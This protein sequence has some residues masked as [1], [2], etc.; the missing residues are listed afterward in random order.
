[1]RFASQHFAILG[2][3]R[4]GLGAA[5]L[6][7]LHGAE[8]TIFDEGDK[9]KPVED[10]RCVLGQAA[11]DLVVKPGEFQQV[12]ISPGLDEH[13]PLPKKFTDA[14]VPLVGETEFAFHLTDMP[15]VAITGTNGKSTCTELIATLFNGCD[16]KSLPCGN[17]GVS[18]SEVVASGVRY[19]V[20]ALEISSFQL[21]TIR[22]FRAKAT[23]WLNFAP[24]HLDRYPDM[25]S[26]FAAKARIFENV[27]A[28]DVAI[29][30]AGE[31]VSSGPA[32]RWTFS[33]Y[34]EEAGYT[35]SA[36]SFYHLGEEI[37][38]ASGL[39]LRGKHNM[40][41][42]L[43]AL[44]T[45]RV[46]GLQ[47]SSMLKAMESYE[48]PRHRCELVR[49]LHDREYI[50]DSKATNLHAL[51]ACLRS[52]ER[53]IVLIAGGKDKELDYTPL[54]AELNG[55]VR[56]MVLIGEIAEQL[57]QTFGDLL[58]CQ[59]ATDM[60][61]AVRLATEVSQAGDAIILSPGTSSFDMYTG[62]A[63]RGDVFRE[64]VKALN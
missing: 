7:R 4:S 9:A 63:Q 30:R 39:K 14:G 5:R 19:D 2:A 33:A 43:A 44:M 16:M 48:P 40:E 52:Q 15:M 62:Y 20:L 18:L 8:V 25:Q 10:F 59:C 27:T 28:D 46:F 55:Q 34:G 3:G 60:A 22:D 50:N 13:W 58:P 1:M 32:Q 23:L 49:T 12:I 54:R 51:E 57:Q 24:D 42:V 53:P 45:G 64:A 47:Y 31:S 35:Y 37:G 11:R 56:A 38:S 29:V 26:Y 21:E 61:D 41:N 17:H 6:A 36:G